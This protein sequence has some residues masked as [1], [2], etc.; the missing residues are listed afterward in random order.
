MNCSNDFITASICYAFGTLHLR[1]H[2]N[3]GSAAIEKAL[4]AF[5][6][7]TFVSSAEMCISYAL[8]II[9]DEH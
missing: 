9:I 1:G 4:A 5:A 7:L 2:D 8:A 3:I 6:V